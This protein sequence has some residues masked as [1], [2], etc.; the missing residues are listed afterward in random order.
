MDSGEGQTTQKQVCRFHSG[1][2]N[3]HVTT[4]LSTKFLFRALFI[5]L[6]GKFAEA[7]TKLNPFRAA[8]KVR[9]KF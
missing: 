1:G 9:E 4:S 5:S 7:M 3:Q 6:Q 2:L 8:N